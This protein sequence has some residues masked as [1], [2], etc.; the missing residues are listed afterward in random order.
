MESLQCRT[1]LSLLSQLGL[2]SSAVAAVSG[3]VLRPLGKLHR[4]VVTEESV[5]GESLLRGNI[6]K[7]RFKLSLN[8]VTHL[9]HFLVICDWVLDCWLDVEKKHCLTN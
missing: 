7:Y 6:T 2:S 8:G 3:Q 5:W 9:L 4:E 1:Y